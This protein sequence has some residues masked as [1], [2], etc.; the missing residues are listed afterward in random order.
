LLTELEQC[1]SDT[2]PDW[3]AL[4]D[5]EHSRQVIHYGSV[6]QYQSKHN[7]ERQAH[8][9]TP[10]LERVLEVVYTKQP[11][12]RGRLNQ[13][14]V[15]RY[16]PGQGIAKHIDDIKLY[17]DGIC[18]FTIGSGATMIFRKKQDNLVVPVH[19][20]RGSV[21]VMSGDSRYLWTHEL[22]ARKT[23]LVDGVRVERGTRISLTFRILRK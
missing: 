18:C 7:R 3:V 20:D 19:V 1:Y 4:T 17:D 15:N 12:L 13:G 11:A 9:F 5:A 14:I 6:Y 16:L 21:Y 2:N 23:D 10:L 22:P 8:P